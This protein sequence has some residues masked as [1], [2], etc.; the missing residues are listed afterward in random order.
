MVKFMKKLPAGTLLVPMLL[1]ALLH[2]LWPDLLHIGGITEDFLG[3]RGVN[4]IVGMLTF[5][6]GLI[7]DLKSFKTMLKRH[8]VLMLVKLVLVVLVSLLYAKVFGQ[9][10]VLGISAVAFTVAMV[11]MNPAMYISLVDDFGEEVDKAAFAFTGLFSIPVI[12]VLIYSFSGQGA[13]DWM[14]I[15]STIFPLLLGIIIGN[16]DPDFRE[17]FDGTVVIL[18]PMLGWSMG[19]GMNLII[20]LQAG[21]SGIV[22]GVLYYIFTS[23]L[24]IF[25]KRVL[26]NDGVAAMAMNSVAA[27][28]TSIPAILA[29]SIPEL[30]QYVP[31]AV[32]QILMVNLITVFVTP[33]IIR[34]MAENR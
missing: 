7:I 4:F 24:V 26:K 16:L 20:A 31:S 13:V 1:S 12:P 18:I 25:D 5:S 28:S 8:G 27:L 14:P 29:Q 21:F 23:S 32:A 2:T 9:A 30:Q 22:L 15:L 34:K 6:S 19:Q 3:G 17:L 33:A 11:S 10:G